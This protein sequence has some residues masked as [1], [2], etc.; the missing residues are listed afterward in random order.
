VFGSETK[1]YHEHCSLNKII[2]TLFLKINRKGNSCYKKK[3][4]NCL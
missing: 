2:F 3:Y 1:K 4:N